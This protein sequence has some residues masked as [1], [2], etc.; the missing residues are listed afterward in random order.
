MMEN[1]AKTT[2]IVLSIAVVGTACKIALERHASD[3]RFRKSLTYLIH[4]IGN[5]KLSKSESKD[6]VIELLKLV[7]Y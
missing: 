2:K 3:M 5:V 1:V 7:K 6:F 4:G